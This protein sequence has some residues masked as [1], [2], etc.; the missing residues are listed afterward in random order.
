[1]VV[2]KT[3]NSLNFQEKP[4]DVMASLYSCMC[5]NCK[6]QF[7]RSWGGGMRYRQIV[8]TSCNEYL[9]IPRYAPRENR[10][11][12]SVPIFLEKHD[13]KSRAKIDYENIRRFPKG[14][15]RSFL[16][17]RSNWRIGNDFWDDFE[18]LDVF[19]QLKKCS[20]NVEFED[21]SDESIF[22]LCPVCTSSL[23]ELTLIGT[24]D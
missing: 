21:V 9:I 4:V 7:Q 14:E 13:F 15:L 20:C 3:S 12:Q 24:S 2:L 5:T 6:T 22:I 8:C 10:E 19:K 17:D 11:E 18:L 23:V 16:N 1:M